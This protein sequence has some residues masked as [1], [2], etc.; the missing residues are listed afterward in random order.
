MERRRTAYGTRRRR[1]RSSSRP[2]HF[3]SGLVYQYN[4]DPSYLN[5][6]MV[7]RY[8]PDPSYLNTGMFYHSTPGASYMNAGRAYEAQESQHEHQQTM[9]TA[10]QMYPQSG[11]LTEHNLA[12]SGFALNSSN[13]SSHTSG[14][15]SDTLSVA[16]VYVYNPGP[17]HNP[18]ALSNSAHVFN[19]ES[20]FVMISESGSPLCVFC[21]KPAENICK[22]CC[23]MVEFN[24]TT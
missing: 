10:T 18:Q 4:P 3:N 16:P 15:T 5:N 7:Y 14:G 9:Q 17:Q 8:N 22:N 20:S 1:N 11:L 6:G 13:V 21:R 24:K 19:Q 23:D 12:A 2:S